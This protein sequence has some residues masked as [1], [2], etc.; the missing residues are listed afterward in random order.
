MGELEED[1]RRGDEEAGK[2]K[3]QQT[4]SERRRRDG[5]AGGRH[6]KKKGR[7]CNDGKDSR[8]AGRVSCR[9]GT[10]V[11]DHHQQQHKQY[12]VYRE[13]TRRGMQGR[14]KERL[15]IKK[16]SRRGEGEGV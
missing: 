14:G 12:L 15:V 1:G 4:R 8:Q 7:G 11:T 9:N 16:N 5:R 3:E 13:G 10:T 6:K 2:W